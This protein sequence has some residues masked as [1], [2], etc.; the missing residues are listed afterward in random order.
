MLVCENDGTVIEI[1]NRNNGFQE[2]AG[3]EFYSGAL[4]P[5]FVNTHCH[6]ELSHLK[7]QVKE[8]TGIGGFIGQIN[9]LRNATE[10]DML[11][12]AQRADRLM[13]AAGIAAVGDISNT[14][15]SIPVK[16]K[17]FI[18]YY[19]FVETFGFHPSRAERAF[20]LASA[21]KKSLDEAGLPGNIV[22]HSPYSVSE[23]LF[24]KI[25]NEAL[26][27]GGILSIHNQESEGESQFYRDGTGPIA[28]HLQNNLG[29][30][31]SHWSPSGKSSVESILEF[32]PA[33]SPLL[34]VHNT[35]THEN[36]LKVLLQERSSE[37]T[38]MVLCP[39]SNLYIENAIPP[40]DLF[41][42]HGMNI[43]LGT[44]SLASNH[45]LSVLAEM[46]TLQMHFPEITMLKLVEYAC[47]NG[48]KALGFENQI[49][50]F[51]KGKKPGVN[52]LTGLDLKSL[53]LT[54][55]SRVRRLI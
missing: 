24:R 41:Q 21:V 45:Q 27:K 36:D 38:F 46:I 35:F 22:P 44:D 49:G 1:V 11:K 31:I 6:L 14:T 43:C 28:A 42:E 17:S 10:T 48:A 54:E 19:T 53:K 23:E 7:N 5:G 25:E 34:L 3:V 55:K 51:E 29:L 8:K 16:Q 12:A 37:N 13:W 26:I 39:N 4:V 18:H 50:S 40:I 47:I 2:E 20:E 9:K 15:L 30:D 32:L 33:E 52:L